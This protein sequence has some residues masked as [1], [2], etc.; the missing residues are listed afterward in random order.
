MKPSPFRYLRPS[1]V[2]EVVEVLAEHGPEAAVLAGGQ[3]LLPLLNQRLRRPAVVVD[4]AGV[5]ELRRTVIGSD[6]VEL[7]ALV[8]QVLSKPVAAALPLLTLALPNVG[9]VQTRSRGTLA[10]SVA[11][12]DPLA[13]IPLA[14]LVGGGEV[15][16]VSARGGR[17]VP[18]DD[19]LSR[20]FAPARL[21]DELIVATRWSRPGPGVGHAFLELTAGTTIVAAA[22]MVS[23]EDGRVLSAR[24]GVAGQAERPV[25]VEIGF[26][27]SAGGGP[28]DQPEVFEPVGVAGPPAVTEPAEV[29]ILGRQL[30][31]RLVEG[32]AFG[33]DGAPDSAH[34]RAVAVE[35]ATR[36]IIAATADG[37]AVSGRGAGPDA[38]RWSGVGGNV[39][40]EPEV[41]VVPGPSLDVVGEA[42]VVLTVDGREL[43]TTVEA[44]T[45]LADAIRAAGVTGVKLGCEQ[46]VCGTCTVLVDGKSQRSCLVLA[47]QAESVE[48]T[49][50]AGLAGPIEE[51]RTAFVDHFAV[52]CGFC[53]SGVLV[54]AAAELAERERAGTLEDLDDDAVA[55]LLS[56]NVCRCTGYGSMVAAIGQA[57]R[58]L[59]ERPEGP[60]PA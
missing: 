7:G 47:V 31:A 18:I 16:L 14:L 11:H 5:A 4:L 26:G 48:I 22:A 42:P 57:A 40:L 35:L 34:R 12:G 10:G 43:T 2:D 50:A 52:Q 45:S 21:D 37:A 38:A 44:R 17:R 51:L 39:A 20:A 29:A 28:H 49:T 33:E 60:A 55:G 56:G 6:E 19:F 36:A 59:A 9:H 3:S 46:G 27:T 8:G 53:A 24:V 30:A 41:G 15:D 23:I 13:E 58:R 1:S 32:S 54:T 25:A